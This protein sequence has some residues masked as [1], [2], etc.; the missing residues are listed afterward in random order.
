MFTG[1]GKIK[2]SDWWRG[3]IVASIMAPL[4]IIYQ[5]VSAGT[6]VFDWKAIVV[7][8]M[9]GGIAYLLKNLGTGSSGNLFTNK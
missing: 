8:A 5:S 9:T 2:L 3:L 4:T 6:L 7:A 1:L